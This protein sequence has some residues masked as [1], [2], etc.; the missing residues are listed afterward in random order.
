M[1]NIIVKKYTH[2]NRSFKHWDTPKGK[3]IRSKAHYEEEMKRGGFVGY[4]EGSRIAEQTYNYNNYKRLSS[5]AQ[6]VIKAARLQ[7][8]R[9]G[10]IKPSE[11]LID[12]MKRVGVKFNIP[13]WCPRHYK[14]RDAV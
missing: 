1:F 6:D 14:D 8:D 3:L 11:K 9:K 7:S 12:G 4:E 13:D 2:F 10:N 5:E